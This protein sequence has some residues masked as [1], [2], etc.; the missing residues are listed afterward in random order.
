MAMAGAEDAAATSTTSPGDPEHSPA[1]RHSDEELMPSAEPGASDTAWIALEASRRH[2]AEAQHISQLGSFKLDVG[3]GQMTWSAELYHVLG[4]QSDRQP[5]AERLS[6]V[7]HPE[8]RAAFRRAWGDAIDRATPF[9]LTLRIVRDNAEPAWVNARGVPSLAGDG[10]VDKLVG[11]LRDNTERVV[12]DQLRRAA[13]TR[14][15]HIFEQAGIGAGILDLDGIP[16]RVNAAVC[17]FLG[18]PKEMLVGRSWAEYNHPDDVPLSDAIWRR[19]AA[20][21][22]TYAD[23]RRYLRADGT[24]VWAALR[25]TLVRNDSGVPQYYLAQLQDISDKKRMEQELVRQ[26]LHDALTGLPNRALLTDRLVQSLAATRRRGFQ[27]GV[28]FLDLDNFKMVNDSLGHTAGDDLLKRV[29]NRI[30]SVLRASDTVARFGGDEFV[31][32]CDDTSVREVQRIAER[33]L[34]AVGHRCLIEDWEVIVTASIG[35]AMA[36]GRST[37]ESLLRD[38][39]A[40]MFLAKERGRGRIEM[41]DEVLRSRGER[42]LATAS[43]LRRALERQEF[44]VHYQPIVDLSSGAMVNAEALLR[45]VQSERRI[46]DPLEFIPLAE[47]TGLIVPIGA[48]VLEQAC[49]QLVAWQRTAPSMG[50]SVNLSVRQLADSDVV[51]MVED[52]LKRTLVRPGSVCLELTE[53]VF[54]DDVDYFGRT[55]GSLRDLGVKLAIDDFGTGYSSLRYLKRFP[56]DALK[57][58]QSFVA[59]LSTGP[60]YSA[61]VATII[62]M[63]DALGL[64]ITA[65]GVESHEQLVVLK[66]LQCQRAQGFHLSRPIPAADMDRLIADA[67]RWEVG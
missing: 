62:A 65:E 21:T 24:V 40:A 49:R 42:Q 7:V 16:R 37:P 3:T 23:E 53:T 54:M 6:S 28:I 45:W 46:V 35:I 63:A 29:A 60:H 44:T 36:D 27:V 4:V 57:V 61:L 2:L 31:V 58:D 13:E 12:A 30:A 10:S 18:R 41:F 34:K 17:A 38:A 26:A 39:D 11:T 67:Y 32:V 19:G 43:A 20:G 14:F 15:E 33:V 52:V 50:I 1:L 51:G 22:D 59:E 56:V 48:W 55:L 8:D 47:Q 5:T 25:I 9:D 64:G 66:R